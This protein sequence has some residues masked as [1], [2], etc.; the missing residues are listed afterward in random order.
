MFDA[1]STKLLDIMHRYI[2]L[3]EKNIA[4]YEMPLIF[5]NWTKQDKQIAQSS[6]YFLNLFYPKIVMQSIKC[7]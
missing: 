3:E 6:E 1:L 4:F 2:L 7:F 5:L